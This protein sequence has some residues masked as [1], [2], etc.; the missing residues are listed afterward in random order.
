MDLYRKAIQLNP[1]Y[2]TAHQWLGEILGVLGRMEEGLV[3]TYRAMELDPL[4]RVVNF[5][6][7][8]Q[9]Y[10]ARKYDEALRQFRKAIELEPNDAP[11]RE[12]YVGVL[13]AK[14]DYL[15][16][17]KEYEKVSQI[18]GK[19]EQEIAAIEAVRKAYLSEG[20]K[21]FWKQKLEFDL[22]AFKNR[23][24]SPYN[25]ACD[26]SMLGQK[27]RAFE[28][29]DRA[30]SMYDPNLD[31]LRVDPLLDGIRSDARFHEYIRRMN[32]L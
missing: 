11:I 5:S 26:Y 10:F 14:K 7:G 23:E 2:A 16:A 31:G 18:A 29:L 32:L 28:W 17:I 9:L 6:L 22:Q 30:V 8:N 12:G 4:S 1:N 13:I 25:I 24:E 21:G 15:Q 27:D 19:H 20:E 3:E